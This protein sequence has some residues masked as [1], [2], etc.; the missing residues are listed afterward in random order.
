HHPRVGLNPAD[1]GIGN[2]GRVPLERVAVDGAR[3]KATGSPML[4][5][6]RGGVRNPV[7][8][9]HD[10][11]VRG[12]RAPLRGLIDRALSLPPPG[13][14][15]PWVWGA[16]PHHSRGRAHPTRD[17]YDD[18]YNFAEHSLPFRRDSPSTLR[19]RRT[20]TNPT[21]RRGIALTRGDVAHT[22][23]LVLERLSL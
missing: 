15:K 16:R 22:L 8:H 4:V 7:P 19:Y 11:G 12:L 9:D 10:V 21:P 3:L 2:R 14:R 5:G 13:V 18:T 17:K 23:T 20:E 1:G 6:D